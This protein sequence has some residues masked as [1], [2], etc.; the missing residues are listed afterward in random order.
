MAQQNS[1]EVGDVYENDDER[2]EV[3]AVG[4]ADS[5]PLVE[6][7]DGEQE[8]KPVSELLGTLFA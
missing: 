4:P 6:N 3:I 5:M 8:Y 2:Y 1:V 7:Q